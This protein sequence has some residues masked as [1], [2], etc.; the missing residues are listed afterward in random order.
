EPRGF[1]AMHIGDR[2]SLGHR[3]WLRCNPHRRP[4]KRRPRCRNAAVTPLA[5]P[6][7]PTALASSGRARLHRDISALHGGTGL[8]HST[9]LVSDQGARRPA[10]R[11]S[12]AMEAYS[13]SRGESF[14]LRIS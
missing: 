12:H 8:W 2:E 9:L 3:A 6:P 4:G 7:P 11:F 14:M 1:A 5:T 13:V 10:R